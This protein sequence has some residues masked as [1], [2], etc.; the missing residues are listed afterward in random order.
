MNLLK[1]RMAK[2]E[3]VLGTMVSEITTP[4]I[5]RMLAA[6]GFEFIIVDCEHGYFDYSQT[7]AIIGIANGIHLPV[8]IRIPEIRREI[9][10]KYMD[11]GA[12]G[13][14]VPMTGTKEDIEQVVYYAKYA[15]LGMRGIS[16]QRAHTEYNPPKLTDYMVQANRRTIIFA[17]I[18]TRE[19]VRNI[20]SIVSTEGVDAVLVGPNDMACDCGTPGSFDTPEMKANLSAVIKAA[21]R[22]GKPSGIISGNIPFLKSCRTQ[23]MTIFS[24]NSEAG[25]I[26][27]GAKRVVQDMAEE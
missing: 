13:L 10:T 11:M 26:L 20:D 14:L 7:A 21:N 4:N 12:D 19:G 1:E 15:P 17:Q 6:G 5:A 9:V 22:A 3:Y 27:S 24:C 18:E 2:H 23:G 25:L 8:I 16:T